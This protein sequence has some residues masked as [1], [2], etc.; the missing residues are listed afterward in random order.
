MKREGERKREERMV[1]RGQ[2]IL[3]KGSPVQRPFEKKR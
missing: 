2:L 3:G 1:N